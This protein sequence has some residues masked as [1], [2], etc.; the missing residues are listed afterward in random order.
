MV[1]SYIFSSRSTALNL[2][3]KQSRA[4]QMIKEKADLIPRI[5]VQVSDRRSLWVYDGIYFVKM[6]EN[7]PNGD[8]E[9]EQYRIDSLEREFS[10]ML[11]AGDCA[12]QPVGRVYLRGTLCGIIMR[13]GIAISQDVSL[14]MKLPQPPV[15]SIP[16][17]RHLIEE[18]TQLVSSLHGKGIIHSDIK[19]SNLILDET[20]SRLLL[21]D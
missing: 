15:G 20:S 1:C 17:P 7:G 5:A 10:M 6:I 18:L 2:S 11:L 14:F 4:H 13:L 12:L 21:C 8:E 19:P 3:P 9:L 16:S